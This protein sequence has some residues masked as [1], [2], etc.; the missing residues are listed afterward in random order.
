VIVVVV[1]VGVLV[2]VALVLGLGLGLTDGTPKTD[3]LLRRIDCYPEA[4]WGRGVVDR[5]ECERRGCEYDPDPRA[6]DAG[7]PV[8]FASADSV[9]GAGYSLDTINE[10]QDGF[11][12]KLRTKAR[13]E[14]NVIIRPLNA[15][16]E[17]EYAGENVLHLKVRY[18]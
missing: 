8:C 3:H 17:V 6:V 2:A 1:V 4:R 11:T 9:L 14:S 7:A 5:R 16:L 18:Y 15:V 12:A 10:R 13:S